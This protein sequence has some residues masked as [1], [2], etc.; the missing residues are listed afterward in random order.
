MTESERLDQ[1]SLE[2]GITIDGKRIFVRDK[3]PAEYHQQGERYT[4][5]ARS[6]ESLTLDLC[7]LVATREV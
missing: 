4:A 5:M 2:V 3:L 6:I 1:N 7:R